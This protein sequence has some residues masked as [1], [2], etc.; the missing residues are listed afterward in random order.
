MRQRRGSGPEGYGAIWGALSPVYGALMSDL[1][2]PVGFHRRRP[3]MRAPACVPPHRPLESSS[4][5]G[6]EDMDAQGTNGGGNFSQRVRLSAPTRTR[7]V[8]QSTPTLAARKR[9][10][11]SEETKARDTSLT[12]LTPKLKSNRFC[13]TTRHKKNRPSPIQAQDDNPENPTS[14]ARKGETV[15]AVT[16]AKTGHE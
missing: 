5:V 14:Y 4:E 8:E 13:N 10:W 7:E 3:R 1:P 11:R 6:R 16:V 2:P 15:V 9:L 12:H